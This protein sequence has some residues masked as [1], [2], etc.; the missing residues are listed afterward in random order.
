MRK[1]L[2]IALMFILPSCGGGGGVAGPSGPASTPAP[3]QSLSLTSSTPASGNLIFRD[4]PTSNGTALC[5]QSLTLVFTA[6][7]DRAIAQSAIFVELFT[8]AGLRCAVGASAPAISLPSGVP[9]S[10]TVNFVFGSLPPQ[11]QF[12]TLPTTTTRVV[13]H[14]MDSSTNARLVT[15]EVAASHIWRLDTAPA[16]A[17]TATPRPPTE[18][19]A[20]CNGANAPLSCS[21]SSAATARCND[22]SW[23]C[24][25]NRS[26]TCSSHGGVA[27]WTCPGPLC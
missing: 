14:L 23:S 18:P 2:A 6:R 21:G 10:Y 19:R 12:C 1:A 5:T 24:S 22:S 20:T 4:C 11:P 13:A 9:T 16:P 26:G 17:P 25:Q 7:F 27:C 15:T 8:A 3:S